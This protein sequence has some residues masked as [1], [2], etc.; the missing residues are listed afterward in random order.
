EP[1]LFVKDHGIVTM[2][3]IITVTENGCE[4]LS[5]PQRELWLIK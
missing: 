3:E 1:R 4:Y 2:E 5:H